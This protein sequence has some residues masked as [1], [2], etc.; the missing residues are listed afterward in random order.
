MKTKTGQQA[1]DLLKPLTLLELMEKIATQIRSKLRDTKNEFTGPFTEE[2]SVPS[3][4]MILLNLL[5]VGNSSNETGFS[6]PVKTI[7]QV[8]LY[9]H[10]TR[11]RNSS[12]TVSGHQRHTAEKE[13][14]FLLYIG[15]KVYAVA[16]SRI[17]IDI[18]HAHGLCVS[19]ERIMRVPQG[20]GEAA[21]QL[22]E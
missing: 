21:L 20:L 13:S 9:N 8:I 5:M 17:I 7:V 16:R 19:Y 15:L 14:P 18:L 4:L 1:E 22:F 10:K 12:T 11:N 6:L 3:E 2:A